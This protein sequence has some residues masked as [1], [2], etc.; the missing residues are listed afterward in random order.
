VPCTGPGQPEAPLAG[1]DAQQGSRGSGGG[2]QGTGSAWRSASLAPLT[3]IG[4]QSSIA[5]CLLQIRG[6]PD[7]AGEAGSDIPALRATCSELP[8]RPSFFGAD[9][10]RRCRGL[11]RCVEKVGDVDSYMWALFCATYAKA[12]PRNHRGV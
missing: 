1:A 9:E 10:L 5:A 11:T 6:G 12:T 7:T 4:S 3:S 2:G 8:A